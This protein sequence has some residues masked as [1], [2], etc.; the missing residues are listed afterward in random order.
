[1]LYSFPIAILINC[2]EFS[3]LVQHKC[4]QYL[5]VRSLKSNLRRAV[6]FLEFQGRICLLICILVSLGYGPFPIWEAHRLDLYVH[7]SNSFCLQPSHFPLLRVFVI[8]FSSPR[9]I[10]DNLPV[11]RLLTSSHQQS[12]FCHITFSSVLGIRM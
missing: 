7:C 8:T 10:Q 12:L 3:C 4:I 9:L 2:Y 11:S 6:F 5:E 1:M